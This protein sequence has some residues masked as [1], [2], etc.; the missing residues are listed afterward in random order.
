VKYSRTTKAG[1]EVPRYTYTHPKTGETVVLSGVIHLAVSDFWEQIDRQLTEATDAGYI[2]QLEGVAKADPARTISDEV[3]NAMNAMSRLIGLPKTVASLLGL[4]YQTE[5]LK[6]LPYEKVDMNIVD[7]LEAMSPEHLERLANKGAEEPLD[8]E[9]LKENIEIVGPILLWVF[10][11]LGRISLAMKFMPWVK[12]PMDDKAVLGKRNEYAIS[13]AVTSE[14]DHKYLLWGAAHIPGM[15]KLLK[16]H[17]YK[18]T[19]V[20]WL[21]AIPKGHKIPI[22]EG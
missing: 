14:G 21:V 15:D 9:S 12:Y 19:G 13:H 8:I 17:G 3:R 7:V 10:R 6:D 1:L 4:V 16:Q 22:Q 2:V 20:D 11:N 18:R 5:G